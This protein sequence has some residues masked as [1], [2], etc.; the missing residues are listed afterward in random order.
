MHDCKY[1]SLS[2]QVKAEG[3]PRPRLSTIK[4]L[5]DQHRSGRVTMDWSG[6]NPGQMPN[7][8]ASHT[9][10]FECE[11]CA[12]P[13][14][15]LFPAR[16]QG[17]P[18]P[19]H[20]LEQCGR[21]SRVTTSLSRYRCK[22][23]CATMAAFLAALSGCS[24]PLIGRCAPMVWMARP[25]FNMGASFLECG[26]VAFTKQ[27]LIIH[28]PYLARI[29]SFVFSHS[30]APGLRDLNDLTGI[31]PSHQSKR[32]CPVI[33]HTLHPP[34]ASHPVLVGNPKLDPANPCSPPFLTWESWNSA[35][36]SFFR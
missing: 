21:Q 32:P 26:V 12:Q 25:L 22:P 2:P 20:A 23:P 36:P 10:G 18:F 19:S 33:P 9:R 3:T 16:I 31:P 35:L 5:Q 34:I 17:Q 24:V 11:H 14:N 4:L 28:L 6:S 7:G 29:T 13:S 27:L 30:L 1:P 8:K 15:H